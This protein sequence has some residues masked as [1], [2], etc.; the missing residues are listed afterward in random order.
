MLTQKEF[1]EQLLA[2]LEKKFPGVKFEV[3]EQTVVFTPPGSK[4]DVTLVVDKYYQIYT[5]EVAN[6]ALESDAELI[7]GLASRLLEIISVATSSDSAAS[8]DKL[9]AEALPILETADSVYAM[10]SELLSRPKKDVSLAQFYGMTFVSYPNKCYFKDTHYNIHQNVSNFTMKIPQSVIHDVNLTAEELCRQAFLNLD[11]ELKKFEAS[12]GA[13]TEL[14]GPVSVKVL[15]DNVLALNQPH[16]LLNGCTSYTYAHGIIANAFMQARNLKKSEL[17]PEWFV[18]FLDRS[19]LIAADP[20][21][22]DAVKTAVISYLKEFAKAPRAVWDFMP[23]CLSYKPETVYGQSLANFER[24]PL[25]ASV[26]VQRA[27]NNQEYLDFAAAMWTRVTLSTA[28]FGNRFLTEVFS[29]KLVQQHYGGVVSDVD[30]KAVTLMPTRAGYITQAESFFNHAGSLFLNSPVVLLCVKNRI[31]PISGMKFRSVAH[32]KLRPLHPF[33]EFALVL[34]EELTSDEIKKMVDETIDVSN[35][36][37]DLF[38]GDLFLPETRVYTLSELSAVLASE[39]V[40]SMVARLLK[41]IF[42]DVSLD[43]LAQSDGAQDTFDVFD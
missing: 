11:A 42:G 5:D 43:N 39:R 33:G 26:H 34:V 36:L 2:F 38:Q 1:T 30:A 6:A 18:M 32:K 19:N 31:V 12:A 13:G 10:L 24:F 17:P 41:P 23:L 4:T 28:R 16:G 7:E 27:S 40:D 35:K 21:D 14:L 29:K 37:K 9:L 3:D 15:H 8:R 20:R 22:L 25:S